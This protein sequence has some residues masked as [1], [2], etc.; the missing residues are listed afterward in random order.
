MA[1]I[2][3]YFAGKRRIKPGAYSQVDA[4]G[5][6]AITM[7]GQKVLA[8]IGEADGGVPQTVKWYNDPSVAKGAIGSG[9]L[10]VGAQIAWSPSNNLPGA[11]LVAL[12]RVNKATQALHTLKTATDTDAITLTSVDYGTKTYKVKL[13]AGTG[14][15][16][17]VSVT[18]GKMTQTSPELANTNDAIV[19]WINKDCTL[20][21][22]A[23]KGDTVAAATADWVTFETQGTN[24]TPTNTD[25]QTCIDLLDKEYVQGVVL[26]T[27]DETVHAY[28]KGQIE[29]LSGNRKERR[30]FY[31]HDLDESMDEIIL[32][33]KNLGTHRAVLVTPGIKVAVNSEVVTKPAYFTA[34]AIAGMWAGAD[35]SEPLTFDYLN[36]LGLEKIY[37]DP[38][39]LEQ[40]IEA[41]VCP[42]ENTKA[43]YRVVNS[44]TTYLM[45]NNVLYRELS[46]STLAD[47]MSIELREYLE[48]KF[49]GKRKE[50]TTP[51]SIENAT[52][53]KL[54]QF[55]ERGW[56]V[57]DPIKGIL[58]YRNLRVVEIPLGYTLDWEGSPSE[59]NNYILMT[60]HFK[61]TYAV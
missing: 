37:L 15:K 7:G 26:L 40:L 51:V 42:I 25:W 11:D 46:V 1:N 56:L 24:P 41:G 35:S 53:S 13:T 16:L 18:D 29:F 58:P 61:P 23:K 57:G 52:I 60:S 27:A 36:C 54:N 19:A 6:L 28:L 44:V 3:V 8:I 10:L 43:G 22:A 30:G 2:G 45:D 59:P 34:A 33:A 20:V 21:T 14:S 12:I 55:V 39:E 5:M 17:V 50:T 49:V 32:R 47:M 4:S 31:G 48:M 38:L 9:D